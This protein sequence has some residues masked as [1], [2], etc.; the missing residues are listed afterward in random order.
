MYLNLYNLIGFLRKLS[1]PS[2][3]KSKLS[4]PTIPLKKVLGTMSY[5]TRI[6]LFNNFEWKLGT[7]KLF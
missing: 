6:C 4:F 2:K 3:L 1:I 5:I 7:G